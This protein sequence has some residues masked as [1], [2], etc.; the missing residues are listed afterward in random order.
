MQH[1]QTL[2]MVV[3]GVSIVVGSTLGTSPLTVFAESAVGIR[4]G[5]R[6][7]LTAS[8]SFT[9]PA[10]RNMGANSVDKLKTSCLPSLP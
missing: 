4:E 3:D 6:T 8:V 10:L 2:T 5:G 9:P 1:M 7:G